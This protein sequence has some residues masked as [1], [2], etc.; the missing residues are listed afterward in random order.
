MKIKVKSLKDT[1][2]LAKCFA[3]ALDKNGLFATFTGDIGAGKTQFIRYVLETLNIKEKITSPSFVILNE[4]K[5]ALCPVYHFDLYR[6]EEKGLKSVVEELREYSKTGQL[7]FIEWA[8]FAHDEIP[9][10]ALKVN[11]EYDEDDIDIRWFEFK[12]NDEFIKKFLKRIEED[13]YTGSLLRI[14]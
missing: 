8:E 2:C 1:Q 4:Y 7:T 10:C 9:D 3:D 11:V 6:L 5:C 13:E 14:E 12:N